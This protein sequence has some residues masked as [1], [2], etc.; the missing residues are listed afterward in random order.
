VQALRLLELLNTR[1]QLLLLVSICLVGL[2]G[3]ATYSDNTAAAREL[4]S[5]GEY[6]EAVAKL[7]PLLG[8]DADDPHAQPDQFKSDRALLLLER[9]M[10]HQARGDYEGSQE[11]LLVAD[12]QLELID[13]TNTAATDI[14]R[15]LYSDSS[16]P[17]KIS[18]V[19]RLSLNTLNMLNFLAVG[20]LSGARVEA[21][22]FGVIRKFLEDTAPDHAHGAIGS[23]LSGF[24][25]EKL[26]ETGPALRHY[27]DALD[28][29][30]IVGLEA[31]VARL[32]IRASYRGPNV[33][34]IVEAGTTPEP[35]EGG[36]ILVVVGLGRV[37]YKVPKRMPIGAAVGILAADFTG[38]LDVLSR[39]AFKVVVFPELVPASGSFTG[40][41]SRVDNGTI[42]TDAVTNIGTELVREYAEAKPKIIAA[43]V[44]RMISR[45]V[46]AEGARQAGRKMAGNSGGA[47]LIGGL[48]SAVAEG[49][50]V[51]A[52]RPD[53]RSWTLLPEKVYVSRARVPAG[54]HEVK[55]QLG[56][57]FA[58]AQQ[59]PVDVPE[60]GYALIV[61][62]PLH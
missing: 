42:V 36:D 2:Q 53:T 1:S 31:T 9:A 17:Y 34:K 55:V 47:A 19:E 50:L 27:N 8:V 60:G 40:V 41:Q 3:C 5:L 43:A 13:F 57:A 39:S 45:A 11:D 6:D 16:S 37:P 51:A 32:A 20:D 44:T 61:V 23:Y 38:N 18:P 25:H 7:A 62:M 10:L 54:N 35:D 21:R 28:G 14:A 59:F 48:V 49:A 22:R 33:K 24:V 52:D 46:A 30:R 56:G 26:G 12:K 15:Y 58:S 4:A 29:G